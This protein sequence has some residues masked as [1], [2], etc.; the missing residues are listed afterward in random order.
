[1]TAL[2]KS[3]RSHTLG[4]TTHGKNT[5]QAAEEKQLVFA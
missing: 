5:H 4:M 1:M 3:F 2:H